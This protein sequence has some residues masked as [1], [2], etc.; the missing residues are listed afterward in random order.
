MK[1]WQIEKERA[2]TFKSAWLAW[3]KLKTNSNKTNAFIAKL[4]NFCNYAFF[5]IFPSYVP[6]NQKRRNL[7]TRCS[8]SYKTLFRI[9]ERKIRKPPVRRFFDLISNCRHEA[10]KMKA[11][12]G[13][14]TYFVKC[15]FLFTSSVQ[16][17]CLVS[18]IKAPPSCHV[19]ERLTHRR[20]DTD[21]TEICMTN[22]HAIGRNA[23]VEQMSAQMDPTSI[24]K[25]PIQSHAKVPDGK[26]TW[27]NVWPFHIAPFLVTEFPSFLG[28]TSLLWGVCWLRANF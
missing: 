10:L 7:S 28:V 20:G 25:V 18:A 21:D 16:R 5:S 14:H 4:L 3:I 11:S 12:N 1:L 19:S 17:F 26:G 24:A 13:P 15:V 9:S 22:K 6:K 27:S 23:H 8:S 2:S